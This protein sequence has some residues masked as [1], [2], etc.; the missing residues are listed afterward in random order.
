MI[1]INEVF[2]E[3]KL[4]W[5]NLISESKTATFFQT[6]DWLN[7]WSKSFRINPVILAVSE[8]EKIIAIAPFEKTKDTLHL[9]GVSPVLE[10]QTV[11]DFGDIIISSNYE[12]PVWNSLIDYARNRLKVN[13]FVFDFVREESPTFKILEKM[14]FFYSR[15]DTAPFISLPTSWDEYLQ[16]LE[17]H[18]RHELKR[19][20]RKLEKAGAFKACYKG[21]P[22]D[23]EEFLRLMA[24]SN[25]KKRNFLS[26]EMKQY[27]RDILLKT[28]EI[29]KLHLCFLKLKDENI[30][31]ALCFEEKKKILLYNSGYNPLYKSI[32]PGLILK[33]YMVKQA[34]ESNFEAF[35]FLRGNERYKYDL[36]ARDNLLYNMTF[37][38]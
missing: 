29:R 27:F 10:N 14:G 19:K 36:G 33:A 7:L 32:S 1:K 37:N 24:L 34:I 31:T 38:I 22:E 5:N 20:I 17:R 13:R 12:T 9:F 2:F 3:D 28:H 30:A 16:N 25:D 23:I 8:D 15:I 18:S 4:D 21:G 6:K 26:G 11:S 35:D